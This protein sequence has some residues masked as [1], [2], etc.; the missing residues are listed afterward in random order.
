MLEND[1][2]YFDPQTQHHLENISN[3]L[4]DLQFA[5]H[6]HETMTTILDYV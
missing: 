3:S 4:H 5:C 1:I 2:N 6:C